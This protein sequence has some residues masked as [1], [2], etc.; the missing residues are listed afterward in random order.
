MNY[1][2]ILGQAQIEVEAVDVDDAVGGFIH[3]LELLVKEAKEDTSE[4]EIEL[5][6]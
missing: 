5:I 4:I 1:L 2:V 3:Y 6:V